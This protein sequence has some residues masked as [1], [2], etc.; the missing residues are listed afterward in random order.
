MAVPPSEK[1]VSS[2]S[3]SSNDVSSIIAT[4]SAYADQ[5][6]PPQHRDPP[7]LLL[8][9]PVTG[10]SDRVPQSQQNPFDFYEYFK[11]HSI[12]L[13]DEDKREDEENEAEY[14]RFLKSLNG[15]DEAEYWKQETEKMEKARKETREF[16][17]SLGT[18]EQKGV[19]PGRQACRKPT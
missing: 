9:T 10:K 17:D 4:A 7:P 15:M 16:F 1:P 13:T 5:R 14:Q 18:S 2:G 3:G 11:S 12:E 6:L 19:P 8:T